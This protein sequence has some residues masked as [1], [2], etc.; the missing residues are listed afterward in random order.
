M[1]CAEHALI[2]IITFF[3]YYLFLRILQEHTE[4]VDLIEDT[5]Y[6]DQGVGI[7]KVPADH[8]G[9]IIGELCVYN[10]FSLPFTIINFYLLP[11]NYLTILKMLTETLLRIFFSV[12][13]RVL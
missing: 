4:P 9:T 1:D 13:G 7:Q 8:K 6:P 5:D 2:L 3:T 12:I 11:W 10:S